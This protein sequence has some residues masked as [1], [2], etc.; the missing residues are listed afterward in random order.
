MGKRTEKVFW[1]GFFG[2]SLIAPYVYL[3][4]LPFKRWD[5]SETARGMVISSMMNVILVVLGFFLLDLLG[6]YFESVRN[7]LSWLTLERKIIWFELVVIVLLLGTLIR[8]Y[9]LRRWGEW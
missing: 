7:L 3:F 5:R 2:L 4:L 9:Y 8:G 1:S 6:N